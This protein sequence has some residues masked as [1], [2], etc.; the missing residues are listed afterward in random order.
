VVIETHGLS[1]VSLS[2]EDPERSRAFYARLFGVREYYRD[3]DSIQVLGPGPHDVIAFERRA[4]HGVRGGIHHFG[5]RLRSPDAITTAIEEALSAGGRLLRHGEH[6]PGQ[7]FAYVADP[8][9]HEIELWYEP[10]AAT[11]S[12]DAAAGPF[13]VEPIGWVRGPVSEPVDEA[14]GAVES[15]IVVE[16]ALRA[17]LRGLEDFSHLV[18]VTLLHRAR[19]EPQRHLVRRPRR[20]AEMPQLGIFAQRAKDRP[21]PLG[22]TTVAIVAVREDGVAVRGLDA[23]DGTP[24]LD[25]KPY[26]AEFDAVAG[27][28]APAWVAALM[29]GYF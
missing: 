9:G 26:F 2:V 5:F 12:G 28:R 3:A 8:D 4:G 23:I 1:H 20:L 14:W 10:P 19:F 21:N 29:R 22:V 18:V 24:V 11:A 17:G 16:P 15:N 27:A 25:L 13:A 6:V 7:P